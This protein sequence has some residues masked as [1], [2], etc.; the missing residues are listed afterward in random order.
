MPDV[1][2][3]SIL[4][5]AAARVAAKGTVGHGKVANVRDA[6]HPHEDSQLPLIV[7]LMTVNVCSLTLFVCL[8]PR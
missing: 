8:R 4:I 5:D 6:L 7:L 3:P 1:C 2:R